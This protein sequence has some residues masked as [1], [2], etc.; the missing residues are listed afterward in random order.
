MM[1]LYALIL[2]KHGAIFVLIYIGIYKLHST[3]MYSTI[4]LTYFKLNCEA[5]LNIR[6]QESNCFTR[7]KSRIC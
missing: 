6:I 3:I 2:A 1:Q 7:Q 5:F 4:M